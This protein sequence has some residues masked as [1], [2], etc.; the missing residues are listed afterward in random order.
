MASLRISRCQFSHALQLYLLIQ[1]A[2]V[3]CYQYKVGD[4]DAWNVPSS[5]N[6]DVYHIWSSN[7]NFTIGD[8]LLFLYP[9][10]QDSVIQVTAQSYKSCNLKD[11]ILTMNDG[12][13][14]FNITSP[15][16]FYFTSGVPGHC[17][18]SQKIRIAVPGN[19]SYVFPPDDAS[20]APSPSY[21][22][23]F[24]PMPMQET[25]PSS[26]PL[27]RVRPISM[28]AATLLFLCVSVI[29]IGSV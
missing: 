2:R 6:P 5:A 25:A 29:A 11:P 20:T 23:V 3:C 14:L 18:K 24:G 12:N 15:G 26:A 17:E 4:L 27:T 21:P 8:S 13:S 1:T 16:L 9:P 19:G 10:S 28:S 22:T 7:H